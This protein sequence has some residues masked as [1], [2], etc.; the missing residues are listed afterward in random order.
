MED[1]PS[2]RCPAGG[3]KLLT[4]LAQS[5]SLDPDPGG[6]VAGLVQVLST[7]LETAEST[8][9]SARGGLDHVG[10]LPAPGGGHVTG[11]TLAR[12]SGE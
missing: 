12:G 3:L 11:G 6:G 9:L 4:G 5:E 8:G 2:Q 1:A 7:Q 10:G